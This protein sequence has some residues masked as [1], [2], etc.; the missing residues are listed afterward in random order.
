MKQNQINPMGLETGDKSTFRDEDSP[1]KQV[2]FLEDELTIQRPTDLTRL[3]A[4]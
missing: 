4:A 2:Q 3:S 1:S